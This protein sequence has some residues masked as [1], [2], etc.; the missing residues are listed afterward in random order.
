MIFLHSPAY[1][2]FTCSGFISKYCQIVI[3]KLCNLLLLQYY[4]E[5]VMI[6]FTKEHNQ[7]LLLKSTLKKIKIIKFS[8]IFQDFVFYDDNLLVYFLTSMLM[9]FFFFLILHL[10]HHLSP[11][12]Y[13][14]LLFLHYFTLS[15]PYCN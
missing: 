14:W 6:S 3:K 4:D 1:S 5:T 7:K 2:I 15:L 11:V 9:I 12:I 8:S 10:I 13:Y